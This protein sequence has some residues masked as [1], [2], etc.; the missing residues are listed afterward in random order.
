MKGWLRSTR[1]RLVSPE[2]A[3][4]VVSP[5]YDSL[6][7]YERYRW[8][9]ENP[10]SFF[11]A[12]TPSESWPNRS[13]RQLVDQAAG[14]L[15]RQLRRG[16][17]GPLR[18][19]LFVY[20]ITHNEHQQTGVVGDAPVAAVPQ[21]LVPHETTHTDREEDLYNY[22]AEVPYSSNPMGLGYPPRAVIDQAVGEVCQASPDVSVTLE[23]GA[24]HQIWVV[25]QEMVSALLKEFAEVPKAYIVDG[26]HRA[27]ASLRHAARCGVDDAHPAGRMLVAAFPTDQL[28]I[29]PF[30]RWVDAEIPAERLEQAVGAVSAPARLPGRGEAVVVTKEGCWTID[31]APREDEMDAAA[32][33]RTV[34]DPLLGGMDERTNPRVE[35]IPDQEGLKTL[36]DLVAEHGGVGFML[37]PATM[38]QVIYAAD[39]QLPIPPKATLFVPKPRSGFFLSPRNGEH[40][41]A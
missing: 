10:D 29:D 14:Y 20:R 37:A 18:E 23:D 12:F 27:A 13:F 8:A 26:H 39:N 1:A 21:K 17:F 31:L 15:D 33:Y 19:G 36:V 2:C 34:L 5:D 32:L 25:S 35:C 4:R 30:H 38:Q 40:S 28:R 11:N 9:S 22:M 7:P 6:T 24:L 16:A 3:W 41:P